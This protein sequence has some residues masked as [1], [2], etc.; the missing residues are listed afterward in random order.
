MRRRRP[1]EDEPDE[2]LTFLTRG[3]ADEIRRLV[4]AAFAARG[5]EVAVFGDHV[6]DDT[7]AQFGLWNVAAACHQE[8]D[9]PRAWP[10]VIAEHVRRITEGVDAGDPFAGLEAADL[11]RR[12][13]AR[14]MAVDALP[15][16][17]GH[18]YARDLAPRLKEA[19]CLDMPETIHT[20]TDSEVARCGGPDELRRAGLAN[21][22]SLQVEERKDIQAP[23]GSNFTV[24]HGPSPYTA[25]RALVMPD[26]IASL[27]GPADLT[28]GVLFGIPDRHQVIVHVIHDKTVLTTAPKMARF[29]EVGYDDSPGPLSPHLYW[30]RSGQWEPV[31]VSASAGRIGIGASGE[32]R[33]IIAQLAGPP[34]R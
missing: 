22:A 18:Q 11:L 28:H 7:T 17:T 15:D 26:L 6:T 16:W 13:Y 29:A 5:R 20:M 25:S 30:W 8:P 19:L 24:A 23:D 31:T 12:T 14:I 9:G 34:R 10:A 3:Q 2:Y 1:G 32:F 27:L 4:R 33:R 21:L